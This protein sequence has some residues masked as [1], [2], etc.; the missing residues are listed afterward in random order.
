[1]YIE[2]RDVGE[3]HRDEQ[4]CA[5]IFNYARFL[6]WTANAEIVAG[7]FEAAAFNA[8]NRIP[9]SAFAM[10]V[11]D[12]T[13]KGELSDLNRQG[14]DEEVRRYT[15]RVG[16]PNRQR[17]L[18]A[19]GIARR[20][21]IASLL[22]LFL[23]WGTVGGG[24]VVVVS[25]LTTHSV[26]CSHYFTD[27]YADKGARLSQWCIHPVCS[28]GDRHLV[29]HGRILIPFLPCCDIKLAVRPFA[30]TVLTTHC[31]NTLHFYPQD[32]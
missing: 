27:V 31:R 8:A 1:M 10:W 23:Q 25:L 9:V 28:D 20:F 26:R 4:A 29:A 3:A 2:V 14:T 22:A 32:R 5:P 7:V 16:R 30:H 18:I 13:L 24:I 19:T 15:R 11:E 6:H 21:V 17:G 12:P